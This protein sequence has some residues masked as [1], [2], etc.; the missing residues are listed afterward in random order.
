[1]PTSNHVSCTVRLANSFDEPVPEYATTYSDCAV[2]TYIAIPQHRIWFEIHLDSDGY[3]APGLAAFVYIDGNYVGN[4]N[5]VGFTPGIEHQLHLVFDGFEEL[6]DG[7]ENVTKRNWWFEEFNV[8]KYSLVL[9]LKFSSPDIFPVKERSGALLAEQVLKNLGLIEIVVLRCEDTSDGPS[10]YHGASVRHQEEEG[11]F[12]ISHSERRGMTTRRSDEHGRSSKNIPTNTVSEYDSEVSDDIYDVPV[13]YN[14]HRGFNRVVSKHHKRY[15]SL[16]LDGTADSQSDDD[17]T[18]D[19]SSA[20]H[21][22]KRSSRRHRHSIKV[23]RGSI[24]IPLR[25]NPAVQQ[26][27]QMPI[28]GPYYHQSAMMQPSQ[29]MIPQ[30]S[31]I[32]SGPPGVHDM[33][34]EGAQLQNA[35]FYR[36]PSRHSSMKKKSK[37]KRRA[38]SDE[39]SSSI[40]ESSSPEYTQSSSSDEQ[41]QKKKKRNKKSSRSKKDKEKD[42]EKADKAAA[43]DAWSDEAADTASKK[44][45]KGKKKSKKKQKNGEQE[46]TSS[47]EAPTD[48]YNNSSP[49]D[50]TAANNNSGGWSQGNTTTVESVNA[51]NNDSADWGQGNSSTFDSGNSQWGA[52][53]GNSGEEAEKDSPK[54]QQ[55]GTNSENTSE[56]ENKWDEKKENKWDEKNDFPNIQKSNQNEKE[57]EASSTQSRRRTRLGSPKEVI[58][59]FYKPYWGSSLDSSDEDLLKPLPL[60]DV[61]ENSAPKEVSHQVRGG[62]GKT[63]SP[64]LGMPVYWDSVKNPYAVFQFKYRTKSKYG[65]LLSIDILMKVN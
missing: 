43:D 5:T 62:P 33:S 34:W 12:R 36:K 52:G 2:S 46:N 47:T 30:W 19:D 54:E 56:K 31:T 37:K 63:V 22:H 53:P 17:S 6:S 45:K 13:A 8:G 41:K 15:H 59:P 51:A 57:I 4:K 20:D 60:Y 32:S 44:N 55:W 38:D 42:E 26:I 65:Q 7:G 3:I 25:L 49:V 24:R 16:Q 11:E 1:M 48:L 35:N 27:H 64:P 39:D 29:Q 50:G 10:D 23:P 9:I 14:T 61:F 21:R 18:S 58:N 40:E 28:A